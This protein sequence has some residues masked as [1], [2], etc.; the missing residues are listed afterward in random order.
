[1][2]ITLICV[3]G[4]CSDTSENAG[5]GSV[6]GFL[7]L[8]AAPVEPKVRSRPAGVFASKIVGQVDIKF[9]IA[10]K[11]APEEAVTASPGVISVFVWG[12]FST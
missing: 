3:I 5:R 8:F 2:K 4:K 12:K 10:I 9:R 6:G 1:M 7:Q 11:K